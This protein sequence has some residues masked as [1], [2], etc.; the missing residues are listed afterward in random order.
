[1]TSGLGICRRSG[2]SCFAVLFDRGYDLLYEVD[3][4]LEEPDEPS[5]SPFSDDYKR[6]NIYVRLNGRTVAEADFVTSGFATYNQNV[7]VDDA[8]QNQGIGSAVYRFVELLTGRT[9]MNFW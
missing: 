9:M 6:L 4:G 3:E 5:A 1:M 7:R 8:Y 2:E